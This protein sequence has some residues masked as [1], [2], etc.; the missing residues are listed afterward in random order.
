MSPSSD[1]VPIA[2]RGTAP[3]VA[4]RPDI[5]TPAPQRLGGIIRQLGPGLIITAAIV[6]SGEL[7]VTPK[8]GSEEGFRLLWFIVV[9]CL[10]KVFVQIELAR[11]AITR[12]RSTLEVLNEFPGPRLVVSWI[13]WV[14]LAMYLSL[15]FQIAGMVGG[16]ATIFSLAGLRLPLPAIAVAIGASCALL[17]IAG[18]YKLVERFS[19]VLVALFTLTTVGA[20]VALQSTPFAV[21]GAQLAEGFTFQ[22]PSNLVTAFGAFGIIGVGASELIYYPYWCLEKGYGRHA[23]RDD[24]SRAWTERA[25]GWLRVMQVDAWVSFAIYTAATAAFYLLGAA[26]LHGSGLTVANDSMIETLSHM[27]RESLGHASYYVFLVGAFVVLYSTIFC[28]TAG[29]ARLFADALA[30]F[31]MKRYRDGEH[32]MRW[33]KIGSVL[34][35]IAFTTVYLVVGAPVSLVLVGAV[36]QGLMVPFLAAAAVWLHFSRQPKALRAGSWAVA[37]LIIATLLM[38]ALGVYQVITTLLGVF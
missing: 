33:I 34:L 20:V 27:Y 36:A 21:T 3:I 9:G 17:L 2:S 28:G 35:P 5:V 7:I 19:A 11:Y 26:V 6:G 16:A 22:L 1:S 10:V 24:G 13:L 25:R 4:E 37:G 32:R 14:W 8:L 30:L 23:G 31:R 12:G 15:V 29:N 18:R 38:T